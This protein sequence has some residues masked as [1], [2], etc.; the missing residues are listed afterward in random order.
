MDEGGR[1]IRLGVPRAGYLFPGARRAIGPLSPAVSAALADL[2]MWLIVLPWLVTIWAFFRILHLL[3]LFFWWLHASTCAGKRW[4]QEDH[5]KLMGCLLRF[6]VSKHARSLLLQEGVQLIGGV[7]QLEWRWR[8]VCAQGGDELT[9]GHIGLVE[10]SEALA[11]RS[12]RC[13]LKFLP[14]WELPHW[15]LPHVKEMKLEA[16]VDQPRRSEGDPQHDDRPGR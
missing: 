9:D 3:C 8:L 2:V 13:R 5:R 4:T 14:H 12:D 6:L 1:S 10:Y 16:D 7:R 11:K 15:E